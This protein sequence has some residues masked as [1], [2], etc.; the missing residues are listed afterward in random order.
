[1]LLRRLSRLVSTV[2]SLYLI[3]SVLPVGGDAADIEKNRGECAMERTLGIIKPDAVR[4]NHVGAIIERIESSGLRVVAM[5]M[6][7]LDHDKAGEFYAVHRARPFYSQ[8][9]NFMSSGPV[10]VLALE[11]QHAIAK[12]REVMGATNPAQAA[13]GTIR[14]DY[15]TSIDE[16]A[17][18][19]S[20]APETAKQELAFFFSEKEFCR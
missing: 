17:V 9:V 7:Q 6:V 4:K 16:N 14:A 8:L 13:P 20:D 11:G 5:K 15:A 2:L 18:H 19:G 1:M 12:Y 3:C 10:V